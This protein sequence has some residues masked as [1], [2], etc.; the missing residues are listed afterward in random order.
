MSVFINKP[1]KT[2]ALVGV[3]FSIRY[4]LLINFKELFRQRVEV[5]TPI[6]SW[7]RAYEAIHL[8]NSGLDP[9][10]SNLFHE[11]PITLQFY[12]ILISYLNVDLAFA[13]VDVITAILLQQSVYNQLLISDVERA[14]AS[15]QSMKVLLIYLFSPITLI[16]CAGTS[17]STFT[18]F[19]IATINFILPMK[20]FKAL[21]CVLC[22][23]LACNNLHYSTLVVPIFLCLEYCSSKKRI[24]TKPG[25]KEEQPYYRQVDFSATLTT[26][27][28]IC[29]GSILTLLLTS[30]FLM[31]SSWTF[32]KSTYLFVL[33]I[34]DLTPNIG[35]FWYFFTEM[36]EHFLSFFTWL[37]QINAFIHVIPLCITLRD[38]PFFA[39]YITFL[40]STLFQPYPSLSSIGM[41]LSWL[42][43]WFELFPHMTRN[44]MVCCTAVSCISLW[45]IFWHLWIVMGTA[46]SNFYFGATL[47]F[48]VSLTFL[49]VDLLNANG[50]LNAKSRVEDYKKEHPEWLNVFQKSKSDQKTAQE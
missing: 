11:Y 43:Q 14:K 38:K 30:H 44:L 45:P 6:S 41:I 7:K 31:G 3:G 42:P 35:M 50:Y 1:V 24:N 13:G 10:S 19:L 29:I 37:V 40:T 25:Q 9:Y 8:W 36:F 5:T 28:L 48:S 49:M 16:S 22:A 46:N 2:C 26:S 33:M 47:A 23:F 15:K 32:M 18:N 4:L 39:L 12:K 21:T 34:Q 27:I 20:P 17:T